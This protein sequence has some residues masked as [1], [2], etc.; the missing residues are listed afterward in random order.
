MNRSVYSGVGIAVVAVALLLGSVSLRGHGPYWTTLDTIQRIEPPHRAE[1][2]RGELGVVRQKFARRYLVQAYRVFSGGSPLPQT[3]A[4]AWE[5]QQLQIPKTTP[6]EDWTEA[7]DQTL[8]L[9]TTPADRGQLYYARYRNILD[10]QQILNCPDDAFA[11]AVRTLKARS[12]RFG[13]TSPEIRDWAKAQVA[14]FKNCSEEDLVLPDA[15]PASAPALVRA[16]RAYQTAAA[17]FYG[18]QFEEAERRFRGIASD[19]TSPWRGYGRYLAARSKIR[20]ATLSESDPSQAERLLQSAETELRSVI[21][22]PDAAELHHSA[23]GLLD[24]LAT[25]LRPIERLSM[26]DGQTHRRHR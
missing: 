21:G 14:V 11:N 12:D 1:Y 26:V 9:T 7:R 5:L 22:D 10:N 18:M 3:A 4:P 20:R 2:G 6:V 19:T 13:G 17:Y 15:A 8:G 25:N 24:H 23:Q 16:D